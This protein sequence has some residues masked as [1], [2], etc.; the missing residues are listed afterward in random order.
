MNQLPR[1][2]DDCKVLSF[3]YRCRP[4]KRVVGSGEE[5]VGRSAPI[6]LASAPRSR[7]SEVGARREI[8]RSYDVAKEKHDNIFN[9]NS[10]QKQTY[11]HNSTESISQE[12]FSNLFMI[13][14][15]I[16]NQAEFLYTHRIP[17]VSRAQSEEHTKLKLIFCIA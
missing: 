6:K 15:Y 8:L 9:S 2:D 14:L 3:G 10:R 12:L 1:E 13:I 16:L 5:F 7:F 4:W 11:K 17:V